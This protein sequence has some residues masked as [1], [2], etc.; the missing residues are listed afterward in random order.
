MRIIGRF[1][2]PGQLGAAVDSLRHLGFDRKDMIISTIES[3]D[4][5][6][7]EE[8]ADEIA[9]IKTERDGLWESA[10]YTDGIKELAGK[11]GMI[12]A[13]NASKHQSDKVRTALIQSGALEVFQD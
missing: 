7:P 1:D 8:A 10:S 11:T 3:S 4:Y 6:N 5:A 9:F 13:V 12:V 2:N